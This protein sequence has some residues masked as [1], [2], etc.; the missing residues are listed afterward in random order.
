MNSP[1]KTLNAKINNNKVCLRVNSVK[2]SSDVIHT[3]E[4]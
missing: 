2:L 4:I 1:A 3:F